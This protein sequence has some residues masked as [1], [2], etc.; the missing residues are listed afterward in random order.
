MMRVT[1]SA[2]DVR[3][4]WPPA[5]G[6]MATLDVTSTSH[7]GNPGDTRGTEY[8]QHHDREMDLWKRERCQ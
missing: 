1:E 8:F 5:D 2:R 7:R 4:R 6:L 3:C